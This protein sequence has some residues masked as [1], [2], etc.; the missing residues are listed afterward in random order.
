[1][2]F[3]TKV[4][5]EHDSWDEY[6]FDHFE[7]VVDNVV[8]DR[9]DGESDWSERSYEILGEGD[10]VIEWRYVKDSSESG[11]ED[12]VWVDDFVWVPDS[13]PVPNESF[14][15]PRSWVDR[16]PSLIDFVQGDYLAAICLDTNKSSPDGSLSKVWQDYVSGTDPTNSVSVFLVDIKMVD[17]APVVTWSPDLNTNGVQRV[18]TIWGTPT[19][20]PA[21]WHSPTNALDRFFKV[22]VEMP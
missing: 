18:Y 20:R 2:R 15:I 9:L 19:L 22:T 16:F 12:S 21:A 8:V 17:G 7:F 13:I 6:D 14:R 11:G 3:W 4:S 10:H 5:C 1:M